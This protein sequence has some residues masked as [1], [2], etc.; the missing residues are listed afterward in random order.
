MKA[1]GNETSGRVRFDRAIGAND[2]PGAIVAAEDLATEARSGG[3]YNQAQF[4][5][6]TLLNLAERVGDSTASARAEERLG[7]LYAT[8]GD[9]PNALAHLLRA[10]SLHEEL[11]NLEGIGNLLEEIG[12]VHGMAGDLEGAYRYLTDGLAA[13]RE[14]GNAE[15]E[16]RT[17][18]NL[19][20]IHYSRGNLEAALDCGLRA[21]AVYE[22]LGD[23]RNKAATLLT[24]ARVYERQG[25]PDAAFSALSGAQRELQ[26]T[27]DY[28]LQGRAFLHLGR[29]YREAGRLDEARFVL[30]QGVAIAE[31]IEDPSTLHQCHDELARTLERLDMHREALEH[32][33]RAVAIRDAFAAEETQRA[34][35]DLQMRYDMERR[36]KDEE[37]RQRNNVVQAIIETQEVERHRIAGELHDGVGQMLAAVKMNLLRVEGGLREIDDDRRRAFATAMGVL[38]AAV[39]DVRTI[40]HTLSSSTLQ[41]LGITAALQEIVTATSTSGAMTFSLN[42]HGVDGHLPEEIELGLYRIAQELITNVIRHSQAAAAHIHLLNGE[43]GI[44]LMVEDNGVGFDPTEGRGGGMGRRNMEARVRTMNGRIT[45]DSVPGHG[46]TVTVELPTGSSSEHP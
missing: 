27:D 9:Y 40:A 23:H 17:I 1:I 26:E 28:E 41:E 38:D 3:D 31:E 22:A 25:H 42:V 44:T 16:V 39:R 37:I 13:H 15:M 45:F 18:R 19:G 33:R 43:E 11:L 8:L 7:D 32:M 21:L 46:T 35:A 20:E 36:V 12:I 2:T 34:L 30:G 24:L 29:L 6:S 4:W 10:L 14:A 5:L